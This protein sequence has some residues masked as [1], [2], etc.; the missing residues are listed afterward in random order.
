[1]DGILVILGYVWTQF[2]TEGEGQIGF[3]P[4]HGPGVRN[5]SWVHGAYHHVQRGVNWLGIMAS[6][7]N[8]VSD[9]A[10][11]AF[12]I[13]GIHVSPFSFDSDFSLS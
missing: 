8:V 2:C 13:F 1:V 9:E 6:G 4:G 3:T 12:S 11:V 10:K 7:S 5:G